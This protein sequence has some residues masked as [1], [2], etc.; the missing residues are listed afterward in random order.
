[1]AGHP[2]HRFP[3]LHPGDRPRR[4]RSW[5]GGRHHADHIQHDLAYR[6]DTDLLDH[7][8]DCLVLTQVLERIGTNTGASAQRLSGACQ[9]DPASRHW[10]HFL[11]GR[12]CSGRLS[13][14][15]NVA[16]HRSPHTDVSNLYRSVDRT[17]RIISRVG[18]DCSRYTCS[19]DQVW[20]DVA[21]PRTLR[22]LPRSYADD[23]L[24]VRPCPPL[25]Y[26][27][28][29]PLGIGLWSRDFDLTMA[30]AVLIGGA[31]GDLSML[32][33]SIAFHPQSQ[34]MDHPSEPA[35]IIL[36][37]GNLPSASGRITIA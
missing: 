4:Q 36:D 11:G 25:V 34:V 35:F 26:D 8:P 21:H 30:S 28:L 31:A 32:L 16:K 23:G 20:S 19:F 29:L 13:I 18:M 6:C 9:S 27:G 1:M 33:A 15:T 37:K 7:P 3:F 24:S 14:P 5:R 22:T 2:R 17:P 12:R 10:T